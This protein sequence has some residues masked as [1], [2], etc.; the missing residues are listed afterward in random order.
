MAAR[1]Q[2]SEAGVGGGGGAL[3]TP[4]SPLTRRSADLGPEM[5]RA[6][7]QHIRA[8]MTA[9]HSWGKHFI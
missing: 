2:D 1:A 6:Q 9:P 3:Q 8:G 7:P 4:A 5:G